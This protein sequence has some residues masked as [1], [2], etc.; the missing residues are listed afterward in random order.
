M[1]AIVGWNDLEIVEVMEGFTARF[2]HTDKTT[3]A[4]WQIAAGSVLPVHEHPHE[5]VSNILRGTFDL[6]INGETRTLNNGGM[7]RNV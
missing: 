3:L 2:I 6:E 7:E 5:Q 4:Y 1:N